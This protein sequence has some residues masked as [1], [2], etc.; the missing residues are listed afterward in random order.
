MVVI[1]LTTF[2]CEPAKP[3]A[4]TG[5]GTTGNESEHVHAETLPD[6]VKEL[7]GVCATV[8]AAFAKDDSEAAHDPMHDVLHLLDEIPG[9]V[10]KSTLDDATKAEI[11]TAADSLFK[12]FDEVDKGMHGSGGK[13]YSEVAEAIDASLKVI[14]DKAKG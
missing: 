3:K 2:G 11:K 13:K 12:S 14:V 7:E 9:L 10:A 8:K 1:A 6:A 4:S 5:A